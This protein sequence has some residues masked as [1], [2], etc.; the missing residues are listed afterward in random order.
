MARLAP[1]LLLL[2]TLL[3][4][5][6]WG[7]VALPGM[8]QAAPA[9]PASATAAPKLTRAE[10]SQLIELLNDPQKR[11]AF[12]ATLETLTKAQAAVAPAKPTA[13]PLAPNSI[14]AQVLAESGNWI[15]GLSNQFVSFGK[16]LGDLPS[17]WAFTLRTVRDPALRARALDAGWRLAVV[18]ALAVLAEIGARLLLRR[19]IRLIAQ[20]APDNGEAH[21]AAQAAHAGRAEARIRGA[22][23]ARIGGAEHHAEEDGD[24][25]DGGASSEAALREAHE[26]ALRDA[27]LEGVKPEDQETVAVEHVLRRRRFSR[28]L[29][30]LRRL[31]FVLMCFVLDLVPLGVFLAVGYGGTLFA[32]TQVRAVLQA[33][34]MAYAICRAATAITRMFVAPD[35]PQLRLVHMSDQGAAYILVWVRRIFV[36]GTFGYAASQIGL[37]FGLPVPAEE[38]FLKA[39]FLV[40]HLFLIIMVLQSRVAVAERIRSHVPNPRIGAR[41][42]NRLAAIWHLIAI[43]YIA[44]LWMVWAAEVRNGYLRIWH[45]FL[46]TVGVLIVARLVGIVMLGALDR[47]LRISEDT[48]QRFPGLERRANRYTPWLRSAISFVLIVATCL[49]LLQVWGI[50][51]FAWFR[52]NALGS[53]LLSACLTILIAAAVGIALWEGV[54][55]SMDRHLARLTQQAQV[56]KSAR[57]RTLLPIL[58]TVLFAVLLGVFGLTALSEF[59]VNI[60][61]LLAG[62]GIL[63]VALGFG[64]QKLVQ[65]FITGIFLLLENAMQVGDWV[66]VA[67]LSGSV[68]N[69]SIRTMRLRAGDGSVHIIPFSSVSTV[70]NVNRGIG[71]AAVSVNVPIE[72][73]TDHVSEVLSDIAR[74]MRAD[75]RFAEMIRSDLQ[76]WGVD[77]VDGAGVTIVGQIVCT[78]SGRWGVQREFNRRMNM[79]F[80]EHGIRVATPVQTVYNHVVA[81]TAKTAIAAPPDGEVEAK[82][83]TNQVNES[84]PPA[85]LGNTS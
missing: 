26:A 12:T 82:P 43:F 56:V 17:V 60:A 6:A 14:G 40:V 69:L 33:A 20:R 54:N 74:E 44:G 7:Q 48:K 34:I 47:A 78:D 52:A 9:S 57:L 15:S 84:P 70:T 83:A 37:M 79:R 27:Q 41:I 63:G 3:P 36:V 50:D 10:A 76:L 42:R 49:A 21:H 64:S 80:K 30:T 66:T 81:E 68:E 31:P 85:A 39:V 67:G 72:E 65:D 4:G 11:A 35:R 55:A 16:V 73:D 1:A 13:V 53:R 2:L 46:V 18:L 45:I 61:P 19:P 75:P 24:A 8:T 29:R 62:A 5:F 32:T 38:A 58:R 28:A 71:N 25:G 23:H 59:G 77:H 22:A 51:T